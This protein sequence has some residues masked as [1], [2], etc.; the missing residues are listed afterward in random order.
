MKQSAQGMIPSRFR[1]VFGDQAVFG[2]RRF[3]DGQLH[4]IISFDG[5]IDESRLA[6]AVRLTLEAE[7]ILGCQFIERWRRPYWQRRSDLDC[8]ELFSLVETTLP[9]DEILKFMVMPVDLSGHPLVRCRVI[10]G[11]SDTLCIKIDHLVV[12]A[13]GAKE[14]AYLL[15]SIYRRL[16]DHPAFVP[17]PNVN[18]RRSMRQLGE[19]FGFMDKLKIIRRAFRDMKS[20]YFPRAH[21]AFPS[22]SADASE[23]T[24]ILRHI[25]QEQFLAMKRLGEKH[26][27]TINDMMLTAIFRALYDIIRPPPDVPLRLTNTVDLRRYMPSGKAEA[28]CSFSGFSYPNIGTEPGT[29]FEDTLIKVRDDMNAR[30]ADYFGLGDLAQGMAVFKCLPFGLACALFQRAW[31]QMI[32]AGILPPDFTNMGAIDPGQLDFGAPGVT[33][34]RLTAG[35]TFPPF[36]GMGVSGFRESLTLSVGFCQTAVQRALVERFFDRIIRELPAP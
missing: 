25:R 14:Y 29:A 9:E 22:C 31:G 18:G 6:K 4:C 8:I 32:T 15:A 33:D 13:G 20:L 30:K 28:L 36:F 16:S 2:M 35:R 21:W 7:P 19:Q 26:H 27:A 24:Y 5:R 34:A 3:F 17:E 10:R 12:D 11:R 23:P 1:C